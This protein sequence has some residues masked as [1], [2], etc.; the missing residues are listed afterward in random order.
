MER[1]YCNSFHPITCLN[2]ERYF[3]VTEWKADFGNLWVRGTNTCWF[4]AKNC[5]F[6]PEK[7]ALELIKELSEAA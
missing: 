2:P 3:R 5:E 1:I 7:I 4:N 6:F